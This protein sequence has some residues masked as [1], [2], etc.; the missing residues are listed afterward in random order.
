MKHTCT[1]TS[2]QKKASVK[3]S[4]ASKLFRKG[5]PIYLALS[6]SK[7]QLAKEQKWSQNRRRNGINASTLFLEI[8]NV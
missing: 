8:N 1:R 3:T 5:T 7:K 6:R 4:A 2:T